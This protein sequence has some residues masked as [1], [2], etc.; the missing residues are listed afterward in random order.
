MTLGLGLPTTWVNSSDQIVSGGSA[1][2]AASRDRGDAIRPASVTL[3]RG[4]DALRRNDM[5][6]ALAARKD[7][8]AGTVER[9]VMAWA[10]A[11]DGRNV[12][13]ATISGI[14]QDLSGWPGQDTM[15]INA[16]IALTD[17]LSGEQLRAAFR[18]SPPLTHRGAEMLASEYLRSGDQEA[19]R[20]T[21]A[22]FWRDELLTRSRE[23]RWKKLFGSILTRADH[24]ARVEY[25]LARKRLRGAARIAGLAGV[26]RLVAARA[27]VERKQ[28]D[29]GKLLDRVPASQ[30]NDPSHL[31]SRAKYLR[32][33]N[34]ISQ[35]AALLQSVDAAA[36]HPTA[37]DHHWN[38]R[39]ILASDLIEVGKPGRAYRTIRENVA[40][41]PRFQ[42]DSEFFAGWTA[43]RKLDQAGDAEAHFR[44]LIGIATTPLSL[45]RGH[46]W[47]GRALK[48]QKRRDA[49]NAAFGKAARYDTT[50]YGQLAMRELG[51]DRIEISR[52][53]PTPDDRTRFPH[54]ELV[55]SIMKLESAG[56]ENRAA[57]FYRHLAR[58][59]EN[60]GELALLAARA[61]RQ[62]DYRLS[63]QVGKTGFHR[64]LDVDTL[65]W[66][67][68]AIPQ[69]TKTSGAGLPLAYAIG[70]Q[71]SAFQIDARSSANALGLLQLLPGT[72]RQTAR[73][74]GLK[75]SRRRLVTDAGYNA[76]LGTAFLARQMERFGGSYILTFAAYNAGPGRAAEWVERFGDPRGKPLYTVI[77]WIEEIPYRETRSYVQRVMENYQ[78]YRARLGGRKLT[79]DKDLR[80]GRGG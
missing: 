29:A 13:G 70:R 54:Y 3:R 21:I 73:S 35:A 36:I 18:K 57:P 2:Q 5:A 39:R 63:L 48:A 56:H 69:N 80:V 10:I 45:S 58:H 20:R 42:I 25:L 77:D 51:R 72:A 24:R 33:K 1:A 43:L 75:Y 78:V 68:G 41:S 22:P 46:Y 15:R 12:D 53:R 8:R 52:T 74:I 19:A 66:P 64:G 59:L 17:G 61:E 31:L 65:A 67:L 4:L 14:A 49:A 26:T 32:S 6:Q 47:L 50:F 9:K 30:K 44:R 60:P 71:E 79:I 55:Q 38:E 28:R 37:A 11:M 27:A 7:L 34:R 16:E 62:G 23:A 40:G 76:R